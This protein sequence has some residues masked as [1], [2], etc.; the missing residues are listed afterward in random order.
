MSAPTLPPAPPN[1]RRRLLALVQNPRVQPWLYAEIGALLVLAL[2]VMPGGFDFRYYFHP[3][4]QGC[5]KCAY[6]P[7]FMEWFLRP[8]GLFPWRT[9][10]LLLAVICI[11]AGWWLAR[12]L[13]GNP[14]VVLVSPTFLWIL[15][16]GQIDILPALGLGLAWWCTERKKPVL[17]GLGL[18]L[19]ATKP[20]LGAFAILLFLC[21]NS[22]K[23]LL[24]PAA[25]ALL[26][27]IIYGLDWP[28]R[29]LGYTPQ[30]MFGGDA[31]FYIAPTWLLIG[32]VGIFFIRGRR[33]Q[34]QYIVAATLAGAP[35]LGAYSFFVV[36]FFPLRWWEIAVAYL[37]FA[38]MG[39]TGQ[40][41]WLG[42]LLAQP[43][44]VMARLLREHYHQPAILEKLLTQIRR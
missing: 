19:L 38:L 10:Y 9:S 33:E 18:L 39:V 17:A 15:W 12:Q 8:L 29:W 14:F 3:V 27:F 4:A 44:L 2:A 36:P 35:Y 34:V 26:S 40:Q 13:G 28:L 21:W 32:L 16:L 23:A 5:Y 42:L 24:I 43:L 30:T 7:Y 25:G 1:P 11:I 20:Q 37:P 6:N 41:W 22:W 31:W